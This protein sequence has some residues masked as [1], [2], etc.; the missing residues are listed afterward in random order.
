MLICFHCE[1]LFSNWSF[2]DWAKIILKLPGSVQEFD[3]KFHYNYNKR[4]KLVHFTWK[5][6]HCHNTNIVKSHVKFVQSSNINY[7]ANSGTVKTFLFISI[8]DFYGSIP[9]NSCFLQPRTQLK[10]VLPPLYKRWHR[11]VLFSGNN[12]DE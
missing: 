12:A 6:V 4:L 7:F 9:H 11:N 8:F 5:P 10:S 3:V 2:C 1:F